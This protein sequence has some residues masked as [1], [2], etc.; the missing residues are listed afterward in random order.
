MTRKVAVSHLSYDSCHARCCSE[1]DGGLAEPLL[2]GIVP[3]RAISALLVSGPQR[4]PVVCNPPRNAARYDFALRTIAA[5][6]ESLSCKGE[7]DRALAGLAVNDGFLHGSD[8]MLERLSICKTNRQAVFAHSE[9]VMSRILPK[10]LRTSVICD[11]SV[12]SSICKCS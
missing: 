11:A 10:I 5:S 6:D 2:L 3:L 9:L 12:T 4:D 1:R 7:R 8:I